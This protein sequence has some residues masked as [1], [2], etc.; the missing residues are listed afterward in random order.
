MASTTSNKRKRHPKTAS[1][2]KRRSEAAKKA[3][4]TRKRRSK[5]KEK[6]RKEKERR[7]RRRLSKRNL[8]YVHRPPAFKVNSYFDPSHG[9]YH[10]E[11]EPNVP[12]L[13]CAGRSERACNADPQC[14]YGINGCFDKI[15]AFFGQ[16]YQGP[17]NF[18]N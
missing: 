13:R 8:Y 15:G 5:A 2:K 12:K 16:E 14:E 6:Q 10:H 18:V 11:L 17:M 7:K 9:R 4:R 1:A 3:A